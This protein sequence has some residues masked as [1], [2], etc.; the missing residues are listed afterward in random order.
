[1]DIHAFNAILLPLLATWTLPS[2]VR[3]K[4]TGQ[5]LGFFNVKLVAMF[6]GILLMEIV[7]LID[8]LGYDNLTLLRAFVIAILPFLGAYVFVKYEKKDNNNSSN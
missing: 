6:I 2:I 7:L 5:Y 1:M 4:E 3:N 8:H